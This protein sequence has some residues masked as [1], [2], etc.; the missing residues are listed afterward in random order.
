MD[1]AACFGKHDW[2]I[3][4]SSFSTKQYITLV[5]SSQNNQNKLKKTF[6]F[7]LFKTVISDLFFLRK[8][9]KYGIARD[10]SLEDKLS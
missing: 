10:L 8:T 1:V 2:V 3:R 6:E 4:N 5:P 7:P 9:Q